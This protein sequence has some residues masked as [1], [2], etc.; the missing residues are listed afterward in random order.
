MKALKNCVRGILLTAGMLLSLTWLVG[1]ASGSAGR[2]TGARPLVSGE[3]GA[4]TE[5]SGAA[6]TK[7]LSSDVIRVGERVIVILADTPQPY[8]PMDKRIAEDGTIS[9][10]LEVTVTAAGK[11]ASE[12]ELEIRKAYGKYFNRITVQV[13]VEEKTFFVG[14]QVRKPDRYLYNG[15]ITVLG[16]IRMAGDFTD[17]AK[18]TGVEINRAD[19]T[20]VIVDCKKARKNPKYDPPIHAGDKIYVPQRYF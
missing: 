4:A 18:K 6:A 14:G 2:E 19:G 16:A 10:P 13:K 5:A 8:P 3:T 9:L 20:Q 12:L 1:C 7:Q 15:D 11:K 17:F